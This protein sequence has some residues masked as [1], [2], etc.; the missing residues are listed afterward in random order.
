LLTRPKE[1]HGDPEQRSVLLGN[2]K[3]TIRLVFEPR[4]RE[5]TP[6]GLPQQNGRE[7]TP[8]GSISCFRKKGTEVPWKL[9]I[10]SSC[11]EGKVIRTRQKGGAGQSRIRA[12]N[13]RG[14]RQD[15]GKKTGGRIKSAKETR[16][17][18]KGRG[19]KRGISPLGREEEHEGGVLVQFIRTFSRPNGHGHEKR[20][21]KRNKRTAEKRELPLR[22]PRTYR[23]LPQKQWKPQHESRRKNKKLRRGKEIQR[24]RKAR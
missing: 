19:L 11:S 17:K 8:C 4:S 21:G 6:V 10:L 3:R 1:D 12:K 2:T 20:C 22:A 15:L 23:R 14:D 24:G 13:S 9:S 18:K 5:V 16:S 7:Y